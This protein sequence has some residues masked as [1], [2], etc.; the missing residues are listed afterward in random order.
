MYDAIFLIGSAITPYNP[1]YYSVEE[2]LY[3]TLE[4]YES[5]KTK[6][7]NCFC[8]LIECSKLSNEHKSILKQIY[9][10]ILEYHEDN[11]VIPY[12][13]HI[14]I[15]IGEMKLL[16]K[17]IEYILNNNLISKYIFKLSGRYTLSNNFDINNFDINKY[18]FR[19]EIC[20]DMDVYNTGLYNIPVNQLQDFYNI[21]QNGI[22][23]LIQNNN[24][25]Y[26]I[27]RIYYE[28]IN[29]D[30]VILKSTIGLQGNLSYNG[31][32][33]NK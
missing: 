20:M 30:N 11:S 3:Q 23:L 7:P 28:L 31:T 19:P 8:I 17:G 21:L 14:N 29:K 4:T 26:P 18:V 25:H 24:I 9:D 1:K 12:T 6:I 13:S 5:I 10:V 27:E 33:F 32:Y 15:G 2:R 16:Q 22:I